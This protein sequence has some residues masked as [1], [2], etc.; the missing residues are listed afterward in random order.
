M[1]SRPVAPFP[2]KNAHNYK[3]TSPATG[4]YNCIAWALQKSD[5]V[6][7]P[8]PLEQNGWPPSL[9]RDESLNSFVT[10]FQM[11]GFTICNG[12]HLEAGFEKIA[13]YVLNNAVAHAARQLS[14][15]EWTSKLGPAIDISHST[16]EVL[17]GPSYGIVRAVMR[18]PIT[19]AQP[20]VPRLY[21]GPFALINLAGGNLLGS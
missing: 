3:P 1:T 20:T 13:L 15:G 17:E 19:P 6:V 9:P 4:E 16:P 18:R 21:P 10:F 5:Q 2:N 8:D 12:Q 7:W 11:C 14:T